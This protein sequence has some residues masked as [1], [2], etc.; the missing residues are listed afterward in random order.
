MTWRG[1]ARIEKVAAR[2]NPRKIQEKSTSRAGCV[3]P[4]K[5]SV[6]SLIVALQ[7]EA[8]DAGAAY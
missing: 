1:G 3:R 6:I 7:I 5:A 8:L 4:F 2:K